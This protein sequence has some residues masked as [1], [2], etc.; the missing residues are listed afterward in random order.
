MDPRAQR[1]FLAVATIVQSARQ[2]A[3]M[4]PI[5]ANESRQVTDLMYQIQQKITSTNPSPGI[6]A[7]PA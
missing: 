6:P 4:F 7:P 3:L 2:L 1:A 5:V